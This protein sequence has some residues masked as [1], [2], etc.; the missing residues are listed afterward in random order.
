VKDVGVVAVGNGKWEVYVG[1]A[2]GASVRKGDLLATVDSPEAV[3]ILAGR[4]MQYYRENANWLE[5]T[6]DFVPRIGLEKI[7]AVLLEDSEGIVA[8]LDAGIQR[9]VDAYVDP[10][11]QDGRQPATPGQFR[12]S[13]PLIDLP[14]VP[15]R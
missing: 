14:K 4:F 9:S 12:P 2:A 15:V 5:R 7:K 3:I 11:G 8:D 10:W 6:Y 1:G 13:L